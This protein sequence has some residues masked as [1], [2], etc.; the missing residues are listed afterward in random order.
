VETIFEV[1]SVLLAILALTSAAVD[2]RGSDQ[3]RELMARLHYR[4]G[5]ERFLGAVK[6]VGGLGLLVGFAVHGIGVAAGIGLLV[7]FLLAVRAH[8]LI[9]DPVSQAVPAA[10]LAALALVVATTGLAS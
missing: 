6:A 5:F 4:A 9:G 10:G 2:V 3:V 8:R 7:Y 1:T